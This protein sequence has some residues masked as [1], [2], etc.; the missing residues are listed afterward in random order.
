MLARMRIGTMIER[1]VK[2]IGTRLGLPCYDERG[3]LR[4]DSGCAKR[5]DWLN[6][7]AKDTK[8]AQEHGNEN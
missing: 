7:G 2:P 4:P 8:G 5:R 6:G 3:N 1:A